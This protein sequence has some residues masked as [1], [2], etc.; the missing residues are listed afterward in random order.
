MNKPK[1]DESE[2]DDGI[3]RINKV[4]FHDLEIEKEIKEQCDILIKKYFDD[5]KYVETKVKNW[6]D[7]FL[8][9]L[10]F[11]CKKKSKYIFCLSLRIDSQKFY[12]NDF[13]NYLKRNKKDGYVN[14]KYKLQF[15]NI[16]IDILYIEKFN[17]KKNINFDINSIQNIIKTIISNVIDERPYSKEKITE[18]AKYIL[19]DS[20]KSIKSIINKFNYFRTLIITK[21][22]KLTTFCNKTAN[23]NENLF[24]FSMNYSTNEISC[25]MVY[26]IYIP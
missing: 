2:N 17:I 6:G 24:C 14:Y 13:T 20:Q 8:N 22:P 16:D 19:E 23:C 21:I 9:D 15:L 11:F 12:P 25:E 26:F 10:E 5:R 4:P 7:A 1:T 18:Y 3:E